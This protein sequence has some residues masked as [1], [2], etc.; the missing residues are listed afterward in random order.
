MTHCLEE[1]ALYENVCLIKWIASVLRIFFENVV[2]E[3]SIQV[4]VYHILVLLKYCDTVNEMPN[5]G[6]VTTTTL[7]FEFE[8]VT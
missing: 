4:S 7:H 2:I 5:V 3:Q 6:C 1:Q 8:P